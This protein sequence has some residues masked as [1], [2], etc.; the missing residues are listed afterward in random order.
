M[1]RRPSIT[2]EQVTAAAEA[3]VDAGMNPTA[4]AIRQRLGSGSMQTV[5]KLWRIWLAQRQ[6]GDDPDP[7]ARGL[8]PSPD[9]REARIP[10][11][12]TPQVAAH[13]RAAGG[14]SPAVESDPGIL[15]RLTR[16]QIL[17]EDKLALLA[18]ELERCRATL[19]AARTAAETARI[20]LADAKATVRCLKAGL[21]D[22][23]QALG[24][25][26]QARVVAEQA[27]AVAE[28]LTAGGSPGSARQRRKPTPEGR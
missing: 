15:A 18:A 10:Y 16:L 9:G 5:L 22:C 4:R 25:E 8:K 23:Q 3:L 1:P 27:A 26:R 21:A 13:P 12:A 19:D 2:L 7:G 6:S 20:E 28:A 14:P 17:A 11:P 24:H